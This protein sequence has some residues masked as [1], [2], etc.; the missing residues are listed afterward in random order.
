MVQTARRRLTFLILCALSCSGQ[1]VVLVS[2]DGLGAQTFFSDPV[3]AELATLSSC[4]RRGAAARGVQPAFP[5]TTANSHASLWTGCYG[6]VNHITANAPPVLP[7]ARHLATER[8][9]GFRAGQLA[10]ETIWVAAARAGVP[11]VAHQP[12]QGFPF[13]AFNAAPGAVTVNG[14]QTRRLAPHALWTPASGRRQPDGSWLFDHGPAVFRVRLQRRAVAVSLEPSG[15]SVAVPFAP[16]ENEPP[17]SR[18][19]ARH[20]SPALVLDAP[21]PAA[22]HFRLFSLGAENFRLYVTPW[23][24]LASSVPLPGIFGEAG[25]FIANG[26]TALLE[27]NRIS[28]PE[29][30]E[31]A[32][33]VIRQ[34][35][36][37]AAWLDAHFH[38]RFLQSYL[39]FPDEFD[40]MWLPA[41]LDGDRRTREWRRW[42][43]AA[44]DRG[45]A[46]FARLARSGDYLLWVSDH[47]MTPI[48]RLISIPAALERAGLASRVSYVYNSILVNTADWLNGAVPLAGRAA[49]VEEARRALAALPGIAAFF[50]PEQDGARFGIGGPAA[51]DLY[52]D[53]APGY[54]A[55]ARAGGPLVSEI[56]PRGMHGFLP[57]RPDMLAICILS[58]PRI[59]P[60][61]RWP[62]LRTIDIAPL[63]AGLLGIPPPAGARG[64][65]P[66]AIASKP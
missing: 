63:A 36:R 65:S 34:M 60:G 28:P 16:A 3:A 30:L 4:A 54:A 18:P 46:G 11:A 24:E 15:P 29:Y 57:T 6:D 10:A 22:L 9:N 26:P 32:E 19:L 58:G 62:L 23:H 48:R 38:P 1:R 37:H 35:T 56:R 17:R 50:T 7:R 40:H 33:L 45:A 31:A 41:A 61:A 66:L 43:Y 12:T 14:Y 47:G 8:G 52:F 5:S 20:F 64:R 55:S 59:P 51:G 2:L 13:T 44:L 49:V 42:G 39:P 53:F 25:G 27:D 21:V